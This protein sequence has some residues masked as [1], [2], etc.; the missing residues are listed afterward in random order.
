[1]RPWE[2]AARRV[3]SRG[4][5]ARVFAASRL[6]LG[7]LALLAIVSQ[8][9]AS[10]REPSF[11]AANCLSY[12][13]I[14]G[15]AFAAIVLIV[16]ATTPDSRRLDVARGASTLA[17][18]LIGIVFSV[19]LAGLE[20]IMMWW[21]NAVLHYLMPIVL[22]VDWLVTPPRRISARDVLVW[23]AL[24]LGYVVYT[25]VRGSLV[26]WY[27]YPFLDVATFGPARVAKY[28][29][30]ITAGTII[31]AAVLART[32]SGSRRNTSLQ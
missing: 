16:A 26:G 27:P 7:S 15:N 20:S 19:L 25:L 4:M 23:L 5:P 18:L 29:A 14:V 32:A 10:S 30:A 6:A 17:M 2:S 12:F 1:M 21:T 24:P 22:L 11:V 8:L 31:V 13:T 28:V 9:F 3:E